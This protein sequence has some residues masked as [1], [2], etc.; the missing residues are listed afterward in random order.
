ML[1]TAAAESTQGRGLSVSPNMNPSAMK[2]SALTPMLARATRGLS[3]R[4]WMP[5]SF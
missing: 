4:T 2:A 5:E 3:L 1:S